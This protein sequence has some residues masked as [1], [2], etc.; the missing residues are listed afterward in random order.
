LPAPIVDKLNAAFNAAAK[1]PKIREQLAGMGIDAIG[2]T[3]AEFVKRM[4]DDTAAW[5]K[6]IADAKIVL[7]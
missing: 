5:A 2:G 4:A 6:V 3:P 1:N 7:E